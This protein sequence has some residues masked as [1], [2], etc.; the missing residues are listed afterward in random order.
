MAETIDGPLDHLQRVMPPWWTGPALTE[1]GR[2]VADV[3]NV[4]DRDALKAKFA[5]QGKQRA[6][7]STCMTCAN[8]YQRPGSW[9]RYPIDVL[10]RALEGSRYRVRGRDA[11]GE[12]AADLMRRELLALG[13]LVEE[14][15]EEFER[16]IE[17]LGQTEDL[18]AARRR[19]RMRAVRPGVR[20]V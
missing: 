3:V 13:M 16:L 18:D 6:S 12:S 8:L 11:N 15:R 2:V 20:L 14:H 9:E 4:V 17:A 10:H 19:A 1:C 5:K 7:F